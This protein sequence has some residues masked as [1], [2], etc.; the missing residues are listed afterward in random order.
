MPALDSGAAAA[1]GGL[2]GAGLLIVGAAFVARRR[3]TP[4]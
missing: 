3:T 2:A 4:A 1:I